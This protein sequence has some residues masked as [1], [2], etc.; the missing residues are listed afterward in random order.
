MALPKKYDAQFSILFAK[1][2][3]E[4]RGSLSF[5]DVNIYAELV[6]APTFTSTPAFVREL[7]YSGVAAITADGRVTQRGL[8]QLLAAD[9][10]ALQLNFATLT[11]AGLFK[12]DWRAPRYDVQPP[13]PQPPSPMGLL[14]LDSPMAGSSSS[15]SSLNRHKQSSSSSS[16]SLN[17]SSVY[18]FDTQKSLSSKTSKTES[19]VAPST[20]AAAALSPSLSASET[21]SLPP[22]WTPSQGPPPPLSP[23][24][25]GAVNTHLQP[26]SAEHVQHSLQRQLDKAHREIERMEH[27]RRLHQRDFDALQRKGRR[28]ERGDAR[29]RNL[30]IKLSKTLSIQAFAKQFRSKRETAGAYRQ[31]R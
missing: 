5:G 9:E 26:S 20:T 24:P 13:P 4:Q 30:L 27:A 11:E 14:S 29:D 6:H 19:L 15:S 12:D 31:V 3:R 28:R 8:R 2:D 25:S 7:Q 16:S 21:S 10:A 22:P 1:L 23:S 18:T 17:Q